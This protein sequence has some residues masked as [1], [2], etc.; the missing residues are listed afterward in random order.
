MYGE[1]ATGSKLKDVHTVCVCVFTHEHMCMLKVPTYINQSV[2]ESNTITVFTHYTHIPC[3]DTKYLFSIMAEPP[4]M[5]D[6]S[7]NFHNA[8]W[9]Y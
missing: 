5:L 8:F 6:P 7:Y 2:D 1:Q 3:V 4:K 9:Q